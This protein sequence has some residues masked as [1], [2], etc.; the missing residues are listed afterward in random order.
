MGFVT[1]VL[2]IFAAHQLSLLAE[3]NAAVGALLVCAAL[4]IYR[5]ARWGRRLAVFLLWLAVVVGVGHVLP[6]RLEGVPAGE[7]PG[8]WMAALQ[9]IA[10]TGLALASLHFLGKY[11]TQFR[12]GW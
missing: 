6:A 9:M 7:A 12:A 3:F 4:G 2:A 11:K 8:P 10:I 5:R 1:A